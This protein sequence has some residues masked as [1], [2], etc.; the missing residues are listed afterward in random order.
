MS[1][2]W[3]SALALLPVLAFAADADKKPSPATNPSAP[4]AVKKAATT[5]A[6]LDE[7]SIPRESDPSRLGL[8]LPRTM[9]LLQASQQ[10]S[11]Q[12]LRV[13]FYGQSI[14]AQGR[15]QSTLINELRRQ[16]PKA[17]ILPVSN[18]IGGYTAPQLLQGKG[19]GENGMGNLDIG[20]KHAEAGKETRFVGIGHGVGSIPDSHLAWSYR[21]GGRRTGKKVVGSGFGGFGGGGEGG[22]LRLVDYQTAQRQGAGTSEDNGQT[23]GLVA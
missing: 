7:N 23:V 18:A 8:N 19:H 2:K 3:F 16:Y 6:T 9:A 10:G 11:T 22:V 12:P 21:F 15:L 20:R 4:A 14:V 17:I 5:A 1:P 13:L